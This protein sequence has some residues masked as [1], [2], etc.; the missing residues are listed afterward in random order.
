MFVHPES[1]GVGGNDNDEMC[2]VVSAGVP[3]RRYGEPIGVC[4]VG[5]I[6]SVRGSGSEARDQDPVSDVLMH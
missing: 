1:D 2:S 4:A 6:C 3:R 5:C